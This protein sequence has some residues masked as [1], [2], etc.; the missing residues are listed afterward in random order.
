MQYQLI[1]DL[2][3]LVAE[4]N[5]S[6]VGSK[7]SA[8]NFELFLDWVSSTKTN[9]ILRVKNYESLEWEGKVE[10]R[11]IESVITTLL[12]RLNKYAK[13]HTKAILLNSDFTSQEDF[14][15]LITLNSFG[16]MNKID[17]IRRNIQDKATGT[18]IIDRLIKKGWVVQTNS[19]VDKR[20]KIVSLTKAGKRAL[21]TAMPMIRQVT[22]QIT[23]NLNELEKQTLVM[24]LQ[25]LEVY[26][27]PFYND[28]E[29]I[30]DAL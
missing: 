5:R 6:Q 7:D 26:H 25:K 27:N 1:K 12:V 14:I 16:A 4:Y 24:L 18:K 9:K 8:A 21:E 30:S 3:D 13:F 20:N 28:E 10:G 19:K 2:V 23:G 15:Y 11:T 29:V 22:N 17:L